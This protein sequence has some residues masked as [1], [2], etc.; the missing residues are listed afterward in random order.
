MTSIKERG[1]RAVNLEQFAEENSAELV[2]TLLLKD[3]PSEQQYV[4]RMLVK[5]P[6]Q[7]FQFPEEMQW[8]IPIVYEC[9]WYQKCKLGITQPYCYITVRNGLV[10]SVT[11]DEWHTDGFSMG[12]TH[13][14][15]QNYCWSNCYPTEFV[16][17]SISFP[18]DFSPL[19]HNVHQYIQDYLTL[20]PATI[21]VAKPYEIHCFDPY[22]IHRRPQIPQG[23]RRCFVRVS[24][25]PIEIADD[26][27][28]L[29]PLLPTPKYNRDAVKDFRNQLQHYEF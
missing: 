14:P 9:Q 4:L 25:T 19:K 26:S 8:L 27:N 21:S 11:D 3:V 12:I 6:F 23:V 17:K 16:K 20:N 7:D 10:T 1:L 28:T 22:V 5:R 13:L 29:N 18:K 2:S 24:Y 15:E